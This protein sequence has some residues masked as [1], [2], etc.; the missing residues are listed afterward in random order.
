MDRDQQADANVEATDRF[1]DFLDWLIADA[2]H[3]DDG[4]EGAGLI[5]KADDAGEPA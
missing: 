2:N 1:L 4:E 5:V 3:R